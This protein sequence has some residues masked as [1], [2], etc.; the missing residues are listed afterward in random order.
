MELHSNVSNVVLY[1]LRNLP[2][3]LPTT[4]IRDVGV[5]FPNNPNATKSSSVLSLNNRERS[6]KHL[7]FWCFIVYKKDF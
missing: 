4:A 5:I 1:L 6:N 3:D 7:F 2:Y